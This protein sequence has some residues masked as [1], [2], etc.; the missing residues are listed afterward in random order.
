[1]AAP[2]ENVDLM[3]ERVAAQMQKIVTTRI[4]QDKLT[5]PVIP[6]VALK[7]INLLRKP[8]FS[9]REAASLIEQDPL[10][11]TRVIRVANSA[12]LA[13]REPAQT[14]QAAVTKM[15]SQK[16]RTALLE[17][18]AQK[19][20]ESKD[21]RIAETF[22]KMWQHSLAVGGLA[23]DTVGMFNAAEADMGYL[24]GLLHDIGKPIV[25]VMLLEAE[26]TIHDQRPSASWIG[27]ESWLAVVQS[28]HRKVGQMFAEKWGLPPAVQSGIRDCADYDNGDRLSIGN[29]VRFANALAKKY[30]MYVGSFDVEDVEALIMIGRSLLNIEEPIM[31]KLVETTKAYLE[32][33]AS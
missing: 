11:A 12:A 26:K 9:L 24:A 14:V 16:L 20:F 15:G 6:A 33:N 31:M 10:L 4:E 2:A 23:R 7:C 13:T 25:A 17:A 19:V 3:T 1:M 8:D 22:R 27:S 32:A 5:M 21:R 28:I 30:E 29:A 18:S